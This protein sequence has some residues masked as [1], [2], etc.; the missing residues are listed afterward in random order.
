MIAV[1]L[2]VTALPLGAI[3][4]ASASVTGYWSADSSIVLGDSY[5]VSNSDCEFQN[6]PYELTLKITYGGSVIHTDTE[7]YTDAGPQYVSFY[8]SSYDL[9]S[10]GDYLTE[11]FHGTEKVFSRTFRITTPYIT[12]NRQDASPGETIQ[13]RGSYFCYHSYHAVVI[14]IGGQIVATITGYKQYFTEDVV[15]PDLPRATTP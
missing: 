14:K 13:V 1:L 4:R 10:Y 15:V 9:E 5:R 3:P 11:V 7:T 8:V 6:T 2:L 12:V